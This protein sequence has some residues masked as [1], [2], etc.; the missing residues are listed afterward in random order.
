MT[1]CKQCDKPLIHVEG[2]K[3]KSFCNP[4]CR[5][6]YFYERNKAILKSVKE[7]AIP[8]GDQETPAD[9]PEEEKSL[10]QLQIEKCEAEI[11]TLGTGSLSVKRKK[12]LEG[13]IHNLKYPK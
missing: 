11:K 12:Y 10:E 6:K 9:E 13:I 1:N 5:N 2:R 3:Q 8:T 7:V 4:D